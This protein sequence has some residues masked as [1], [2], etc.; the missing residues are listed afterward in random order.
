MRLETDRSRPDG[1]QGGSSEAIPPQSSTCTHPRPARWLPLFDGWTVKLCQRC[2]AVLD[3][4]QRRC[5][6]KTRQGS[7][8]LPAGH[9][10]HPRWA[11]PHGRAA[12]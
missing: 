3:G 10:N 11:V 12:A 2:A 5:E 1:N 8:S 4:P 6:A 9:P 7:C